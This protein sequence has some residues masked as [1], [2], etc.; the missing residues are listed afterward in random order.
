MP[1]S[2]TGQV[3]M[4]PRIKEATFLAWCRSFGSGQ[5]LGESL[6]STHYVSNFCKPP[7][8]AYRSIM[9]SQ[10]VTSLTGVNLHAWITSHTVILNILPAMCRVLECFSSFTKLLQWNS[11]RHRN[12]P[13]WSRKTKCSRVKEN[14]RDLL[15]SFNM[16]NRPGS[17]F[18]TCKPPSSAYI[19][20]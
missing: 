12:S 4:Q 2:P 13:W 17:I 7:L 1:F 10:V 11:Y 18:Q 20:D 6:Y 16:R 15:H 9:P 5:H 3:S 14:L 19:Q 8:A